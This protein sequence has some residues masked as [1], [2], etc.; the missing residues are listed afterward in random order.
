[1]CRLDFVRGFH[2]S[3]VRDYMLSSSPTFVVGE[4]WVGSQDKLLGL[5]MIDGSTD[6]VVQDCSICTPCNGLM[7][8]CR[9]PSPTM[10]AS[11]SIT[12]YKIDTR[13]HCS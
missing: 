11:L 3:H 1:M 4:F 7:C 12:R 8:C 5:L 6:K 9:T 10:V 2:G 13:R